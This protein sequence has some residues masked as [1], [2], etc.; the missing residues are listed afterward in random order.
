MGYAAHMK[1]TYD[2]IKQLLRCI[3]YNQLHW[4]LWQFEGCCLCD[5]FT[6]WIHKVLLF[7]MWMRQACKKFP[8]RQERLTTPSI[9]GV[10]QEKHSA[11]TTCWIKQHF[12]LPLHIKLGLMKNFVKAM[13][14]T[15]QAFKYLISKFPRLSDAKIK[16]GVFIGPQIRQLLRDSE[17][18]SALSIKLWSS[19]WRTRWAVSRRYFIHWE[20]VTRQ[21]EPKNTC[22][23]LLDSDTWCSL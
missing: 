23:L 8:L 2:N 6:G 16:E 7:S 12:V 19:K 15:D 9:I 10:W 4:Q 17:F 1:E 5:G 20:T 18:D 11:C 14:K 3:N 13:E 22:R 21:M